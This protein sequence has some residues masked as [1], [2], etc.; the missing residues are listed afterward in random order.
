[1][2]IV[3]DECGPKTCTRSREVAKVPANSQG[4]AVRLIV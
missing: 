4:R 2:P 1:M 3:V